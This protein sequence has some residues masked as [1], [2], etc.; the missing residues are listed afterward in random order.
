MYVAKFAKT[1]KRGLLRKGTSCPPQTNRP[2]PRRSHSYCCCFDYY[3]L[4][5]NRLPLL[6]DDPLFRLVVFEK[7]SKFVAVWTMSSLPIILA[8]H[9]LQTR[10]APIVE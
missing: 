10:L 4:A 1:T 8:C 3:S 9:S 6:W 7:L 2:R 5:M